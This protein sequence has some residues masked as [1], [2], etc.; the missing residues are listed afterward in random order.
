[1]GKNLLEQTPSHIPSHIHPILLARLGHGTD[2]V[3]EILESELIP[4]DFLSRQIILA[5]D[6]RA[7]LR[8]VKFR[9][10]IPLAQPIQ[11]LP[12]AL[13]IRPEPKALRL[14]PDTQARLVLVQRLQVAKVIV[15]LGRAGAVLDV[16]G[17][18]VVH[19]VE[20]VAAVHEGEVGRRPGREPVAQ[21]RDHASGID[22]VV[23][24]IGEPGDGEFEFA[25]RGFHV[26]GVLG[27]PGFGPI[28]CAV[29]EFWLDDDSPTWLRR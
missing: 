8:D 7:I 16:V 11:Q 6:A 21:L 5:L 19:A 13:R 24:W 1:M 12:E 22:A 3:T 9:P 27:V 26:F 29:S 28:A 25:C 18:V 20:V 2:V 4:E 15:R 17:A 10:P 23:D 14:R